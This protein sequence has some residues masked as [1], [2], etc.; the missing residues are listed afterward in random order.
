MGSGYYQVNDKKKSAL[1]L[2]HRA[3][4]IHGDIFSNVLLCISVY[5]YEVTTNAP[6][7]TDKIKRQCQ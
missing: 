6:Y 7:V 5:L 1:L 4:D 2:L 3:Q